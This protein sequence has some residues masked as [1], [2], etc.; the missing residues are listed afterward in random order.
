MTRDKVDD[1]DRHISTVDL[2]DQPDETAS[3]A[4]PTVVAVI[5]THN[6]GD[7]LEGCLS[8]M[9]AQEYP[10]LTTLVVDVASD[11]DL[12]ER[13][14][15]SMPTAFVRRVEEDINF[16]AAV[17]EAV[18]S[19][20]GATY[21]LICHDDVIIGNRAIEEMVEEA[22]R[23]NASIVG[24]KIIDADKTG[25]LL[26]VGGMIDHFG[27]PFSGIEPNEVDQGQHDGVRDVFFV[28]SATMLVR[29]DLFRALGGFDVQCFPGAEDIDL[30]WRAHLVGARVLVQ[31]DAVVKHH[32]ASD[33]QRKSRTSATAIVARH[34]MRAVLKNASPVSLAWI[35]PCAFFLHSIEGITWLL[36]A[37][38]RR[39]WLLFS[40]WIWN[41]RHI[42]DTRHARSE[43]QKTRQVSDRVIATHQIGGSARIRRFFT[44]IVES[45]QLKQFTKASK[46]FATTQYSHRTRETPIYVSAIILYL[47]ATRSLFFNGVTDVGG[48]TRWP[49]LSQQVSALF[50]GGLP[51]S[52][53][54]MMSTT[55]SRLI[56]L[57]LT[58]ASGGHAGLAQTLF[59]VA[60]IP[61]GAFGVRLLLLQRAIGPRSIALAVITYGAFGLGLY[62]FSRG[63]FG[64]MVLMAGLPFF[65]RA[66]DN[67][68]TRQLGFTAAILIAFYPPA[69]IVCAVL[70]DAFVL[71]GERA[72]VENPALIQM[73]D[74]GKRI[75][76][77]VF[78]GI[79]ALAINCGLI[80]DSLRGVDRN[81]F[82]LSD[83]TTNFQKYLFPNMTLTLCIY[84][85][86]AVC[87]CA[88]IVGRN[89]RTP[90]IRILAI[91]TSVIALCAYSFIHFAQPFISHAALFV[92]V[93][94]AGSLSLGICIHTYSDEMKLRSLGAF[95]FVTSLSIATVAFC[96][97]INIP[98]LGQGALGLP[99]RSWSNQIESTHNERLLYIGDARVLPGRAVMAPLN[100]SFSLSESS[101]VTSSYGST[102]PASSIDEDVRE[103]YSAMMSGDTTNAGLLLARMSIGGVVVPESRAPDTQQIETDIQLLNALDRQSDLVRTRDREGLIVYQNTEFSKG[104]SLTDTYPSLSPSQVFAL[105]AEESSKIFT[106]SPSSVDP[107]AFGI[108]ASSIGMI[109]LVLLWPRRHKLLSNRSLVLNRLI[110]NSH[111][112]AGAP[113]KDLSIVDDGEVDIDL[114]KEHLIDEIKASEPVVRNETDSTK[115]TK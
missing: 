14:A 77:V 99:S 32:K 91:A 115:V 18:A 111:T 68:L 92:L 51:V 84:A 8:S 80:F 101:G 33:R 114:E 9:A 2:L 104:F 10:D 28:S 81:I 26:E 56:A 19:I 65:L 54:A 60:L 98:V 34:R 93:Q 75:R 29:A 23:S 5:V 15:Q 103:I 55:F 7:W 53:N 78:A 86:I 105:K 49:S 70:C 48:F 25:K 39:A 112:D 102:G 109:V 12:S 110:S 113:G 82:G 72:D 35:L 73:K 64:A 46:T 16:A 1:S 44:S 57:V 41:I 62:S 27:V 85:S 61:M 108:I 95:H 22:F 74:V 43:I 106:H 3:F 67:R 107:I 21:V 76:T 94:L 45:R 30:A 63:D 38:P 83:T 71:V 13:V 52:S 36:R 31:P 11:A 90:D 58:F 6:P 47:V 66:L 100:R 69:I 87:I 79:I 96:V 59:V 4:W 17:N 42:R 50:H 40:G 97:L 24:P 89:E 88:L 37:D 20:E